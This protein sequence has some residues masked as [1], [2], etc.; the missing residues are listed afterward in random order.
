MGGACVIARLLLFL[1][2]LLIRG[3]VQG[4]ISAFHHRSLSLPYGPPSITGLGAQLRRLLS[5]DFR[6]LDDFR[7][8]DR[9]RHPVRKQTP[10]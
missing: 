5:K 6:S 2:G 1:L 9:A 7:A 3:G 8:A 4:C 10:E